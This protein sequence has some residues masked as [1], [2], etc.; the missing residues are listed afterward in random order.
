MADAHRRAEL[1]SRIEQRRMELGERTDVSQR[2]RDLSASGSRFPTPPLH[3]RRSTLT[4]VII[5]A[6]AGVALLAIVAI[7]TLVIA[8]G[9]WTQNAL[10]SPSTT[11]EDFY[12]A[13]HQ[14]DYQTAY[15]KLSSAAQRSLS[16]SRFAQTMRATDLIS[17]GVESYSVVSSVVN[18]ATASVTVDVVR[19]GDTTTATVY[20]LTLTQEQQTWRIVTIRQTGQTTAPTPS[21]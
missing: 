17:G 1:A 21:S 10:N 19:S 20:Q 9:V 12:S 6:V 11:V 8:S 14:Q 13:V 2:L 5:A 16:E 18:G 15:A 4:T 3:E 7:A